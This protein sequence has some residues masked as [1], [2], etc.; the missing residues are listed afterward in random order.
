MFAIVERFIAS[1]IKDHGNHL[2]STDG[3]GTIVYKHAD[4]EIRHHVH[5]T[6]K[7]VL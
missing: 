1:L 3:R 6:M 4:L 7:K 2:V 5:P